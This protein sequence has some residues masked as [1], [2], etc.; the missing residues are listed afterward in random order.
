VPRHVACALQGDYVPHAAAMIHSALSHGEDVAVHVLHGPDLGRRTRR[1]LARMDDRVVLH[2]VAPGA[3]EGLPVTEYFTQAMW[4]RLFLADM[5]DADRVLYVDCDVIVA[6]PLEP[7]FATDLSGMHVAAV[8]NVPLPWLSDRAAELG[9]ERYFNSGVLLLNLAE[10][11][12]DGAL[13]EVL[14]FARREAARLVW[15][16][17]DALNVVL[18]ARRVA[19]HPRWN[20]M[21]ALLAFPEGE[22]T[23]GAQAVA[24]ARNDPGIRHY[25]GP[26][27]NKPWDAEF[28]LPHGELYRDHLRRTPFGRRGLLRA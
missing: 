21:N 7:L 23:F 9:L 16:D 14:A 15:P 28:A 25:E 4:Y 27:A 19:L 8:E 17:Q 20:V 10:L 26:G 22:A 5:V 2:T 6:S 1:R 13:E 12:A 11:R 3:V 18:G 24:E